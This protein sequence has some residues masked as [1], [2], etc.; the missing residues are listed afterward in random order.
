MAPVDSSAVKLVAKREI[1]TRG[2]DRAFLI[3]SL[4]SVVVLIGIILINS[5]TSGSDEFKVGVVGSD[6]REI[7]AVAMER[8]DLFNAT[9]EEHVYDSRQAAEEALRDGDVNVVL[10]GSESLL[11]ERQPNPQLEALLSVVHEQIS[12]ERALEAEGLD[13]DQ[14]ATVL[15][16]PALEVQTLEPL[17]PLNPRQ[18]ENK[19]IAF[20]GIFL[21]YGQILGYGIWIAMGVVEEK[22]SRVVELLLATVR[23]SE[24][25]AGKVLGIGALGLAQLL[26]MGVVALGA[27]QITGSF[28]SSAS[29]WL[30]IGN[31]VLWFLLGYAFYSCLFAAAGARVSR[32]EE[33]QN[34]TSPF[35]MVI[36]AAFFV[37]IFSQG[38]PSSRIAVI[39]SLLPPF[40]PLV[41]PLRIAA[42][43]APTWQVLLSFGLTAGA[44]VLLIP[45]A[46]RVYRGAVL[47]TGGTVKWKDAF[48]ARTESTLS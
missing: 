28:H 43:V 32:Q 12:V 41:M 9:L 20:I 42:G 18:E 25:L 19:T 10:L 46:A 16:P 6:A 8:Q 29:A 31:V 1:S 44:T 21:L 38:D 34:A 22:Q 40:A 37:A 17:E 26:G 7:V 30:T 35:S 24:L 15:D 2:R 27:A 13:E 47:Q 23:P 33:V 39:T 36:L 3:S 45:L 48:R 4:I 5:F 11:S 14:I